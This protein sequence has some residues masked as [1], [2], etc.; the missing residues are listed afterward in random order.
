MA[1]V[2]SITRKQGDTFRF[3]FRYEISGEPVNL[4]GY[5][6][7]M[8]VRESAGSNNLYLSLTNGSGVTIGGAGNNR[9]SFYAQN[10]NDVPIGR[11]QYDIEFTEPGGDKFTYLGG[12][13]I[14]TN[15]VS[16]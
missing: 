4:S 1:G 7:K 3:A 9:V 15:Q 11:W 5:T 14:C 8:Q 16:V 13:F 6:I 10:L 12:P 2:K